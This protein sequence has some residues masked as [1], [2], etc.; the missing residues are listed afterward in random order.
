MISAKRPRVTEIT[1]QHFYWFG[2]GSYGAAQSVSCVAQEPPTRPEALLP[3]VSTLAIQESAPNEPAGGA[4]SCD[5]DGSA[6]SEVAKQAASPPTTGGRPAIDLTGIDKPVLLFDTE[7]TGLGTP[8]ICQLS[9]VI[10][11]RDGTEEHDQILKLPKGVV[12]SRDAAS[13]HGV[14]TAR[15]QKGADAVSELQLFYDKVEEVRSAGGLIVAH[16]AA[17]DC[18]A[19]KCSCEK[20]GVQRV[21]DAQDVFCTMK[22]SA[23][24][25]PL[26][27]AKGA[28]KNF[29]L[30]E[31]Y[32][33]LFGS[34]PEWARLHNSLDD[35]RVLSACFVKGRERG[36]W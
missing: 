10:L 15:A 23:C 32:S 33:F 5:A 4:K 1:A 14:T 18:R 22:A 26:K 6:Q 9:Y 35:T 25:S 3:A 31:L 21:L 8:C 29:R 20:H 36:W 27:T 19:L 13:I 24:Y 11:K 17:F 7:T 2:K 16:N 28:R 34:A 12:I 30:D